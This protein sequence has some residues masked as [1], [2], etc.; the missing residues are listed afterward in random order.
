M[1]SSD[2][3]EKRLKKIE[4]FLIIV[5]IASFTGVVG[6][7]FG[8]LFLKTIDILTDFR[9][10][11]TY[12]ILL[13]PIIGIIIVY[14]TKKYKS[15]KNPEKLINQAI[16]KDE[17]IPSYITPTLFA[18]TALSHLAGASV[19]KI[20]V[21]T[22]MGGSIGAYIAK[23]FNLKKEN[24]GTIIASGVAGLF[25]S[26][27]GTPLTGTIF[28][29]ELCFSK[30]NKKP[31]YVLP[32]LLA[33][34]FS[35]FICFAFGTNSFIDRLLYIHHA[36]F[37][38]KHIIPIIILI[39]ICLAFA[40]AF[41]NIL[42]Y[43]EETFHKIK[44][45]YLRIILGS[46]IMIGCIYLIGNTLFCG[47]ETIL[48]EKALENNSMWYTFILKTLLTALC[49]AVGFKGGNIGPALISGITL[50]ILISSLMGIDPQMG[51]A[52]GAVSLFGGVTGCYISAIFLG[53]EIFGLKSLVFYLIIALMLKYFINQELIKRKF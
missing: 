52:I 11:F 28:A 47:N 30:K 41:N 36:D 9:N 1:D 2:K 44:N 37:E 31:I 32:V 53:I 5:I 34:S 29:C 14:I 51:A 40:L 48:V 27:F 18:T 42:K 15:I 25:A 26:I 33:A 35:R 20:E 39:G 12:I 22:E 8:A 21:P 46:I 50:G 3:L 49:L 17:E 23:F 10:A 24:R 16:T 4:P 7:V 19:G 43:A 38:L 45:E 6:G 13:M